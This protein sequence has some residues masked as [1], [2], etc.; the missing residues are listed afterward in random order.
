MKSTFIVLVISVCIGLLVLTGYFVNT[1]AE[2]SSVRFATEQVTQDILIVRAQEISGAITIERV[3][4]SKSGFVVLRSSDGKR[5]GQIVE[6]SSYLEVGTHENVQI[7]L[8][9]F[10][11]YDKSDQLV[12]M[13][14]PDDGDATF[15]GL[16]QPAVDSE[17][18]MWGVFVHNGMTVPLS[19]FAQQVAPSNGMSVETVLYTNSGFSPA[20][21]TVPAGTIVEF[22]NQ[23]DADMWVASNVHPSHEIL[24]TFDQFSGSSKGTSYMYTFDQKGT[25]KYHDHINA[26]FEGTIVVE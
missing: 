19:V 2:I 24:P 4:M 23:S 11:E 5:I 22:V 16:D 21:L 12:V 9:D 13:V 14:Y 18:N 20:H 10:Y 17:G 3:E 26:A 6:I 8:G 15:T 1:K 7:P 25:W